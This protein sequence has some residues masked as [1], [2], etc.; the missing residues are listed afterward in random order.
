MAKK[1]TLL[2][3]LQEL[4]KRCMVVLISMIVG[5]AICYANYPIITAIFTHPFDRMLPN[6]ST[7]N[8]MSIYDGFF[9]KIKL[10]IVCGCIVCTPIILWHGCRFIFPG[11]HRSEKKWAFI[12]I[13]SSSL[14][15]IFSTLMGYFYAF[16]A[17]VQLL[18]T[19]EFIPNNVSILLNYKQSMSYI[20]SFL[21][22][23]MIVFQLPIVLE[24]L[25]A[26]DIISRKFLWTH[27]KWF[28]VGII[29]FCAIITPPDIISQL[30]L[31]IPLM[32]GYYMCIGFA[33][34]M[35]WGS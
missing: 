21:I 13:I 20:I 24:W 31:A 1:M 23:G 6:N 27:A 26:N 9:V 29:I 14:L 32:I 11:L 4:R 35:K 28:M 30:C 25:L 2:G 18:T 12:I 16:P 19:S 34:L 8:I 10:S 33:K 15:A 3:H 7:I 5:S 22:G 17:I